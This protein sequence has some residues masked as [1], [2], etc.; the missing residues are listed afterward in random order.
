VRYPK[1]E[2]VCSDATTQ[3]ANNKLILTKEFPHTFPILPTVE[4]DLFAATH[5]IISYISD[6]EACVQTQ[7]TY[8]ASL[9]F[10]SEANSIQICGTFAWDGRTGNAHVRAQQPESLRQTAS[11]LDDSN[12]AATS[13]GLQSTVVL[14]MRQN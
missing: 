3:R 8:I 1:A 2:K 10:A 6:A 5:L 7:E 4:Q 9:D 12:V 13:S 14:P 11:V